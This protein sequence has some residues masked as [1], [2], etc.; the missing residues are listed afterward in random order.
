MMD[1][2][3]SVQ[4]SEVRVSALLYLIVKHE[5]VKS[6]GANKEL[7]ARGVSLL[8]ADLPILVKHA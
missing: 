1:S 7:S 5:M 4:A 2:R 3:T 6:C 8:L